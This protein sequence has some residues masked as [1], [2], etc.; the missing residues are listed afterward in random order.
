MV[1]EG[2]GVDPIAEGDGWSRMG[3]GQGRWEVHL[4]VLVGIGI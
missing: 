2:R 3:Y 1:R 4:G